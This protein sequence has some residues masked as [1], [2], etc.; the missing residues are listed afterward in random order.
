MSF[1]PTSRGQP[2][3]SSPPPQR[4]DPAYGGEYQAY[5]R[6]YRAWNARAGR[7]RQREL[8]SSEL[9]GSIDDVTV[10]AHHL[11]KPRGR[12]P[13][14]NG[15]ACTWDAGFWRT[16]SGEVH[17]GYGNGNRPTVE[18][19]TAGTP[20]GPTMYADAMATLATQGDGNAMRTMARAQAKLAFFDSKKQ[21]AATTQDE[22]CASVA[23]LDVATQAALRQSELCSG[24]GFDICFTGSIWSRK[25][26]GI[27]DLSMS[28][29]PGARACR[30]AS[31]MHAC[32]LLTPRPRPC[33]DALHD[34]HIKPSTVITKTIRDCWI[35]ERRYGYEGHPAA[36][37]VEDFLAKIAELEGRQRSTFPS[38]KSK[39]LIQ[40]STLFWQ[41]AYALIAED[42]SYGSARRCMTSGQF[43]YHYKELMKTRLAA[44]CDERGRQVDEYYRGFKRF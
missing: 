9:T 10:H 21:E 1:V 29:R 3:A 40:R 32:L 14:A 8:T 36:P 19:L 37:G 11:K 7:K 6:A 18:T 34:V 24:L 38:E 25:P 12:A 27:N 26:H 15:V 42:G 33:P 28:R 44:L 2:L 22:L 43:R 31:E 39:V 23:R 13:L 30:P 16:S 5:R 17:I 41:Q 4:E 35:G 20:L